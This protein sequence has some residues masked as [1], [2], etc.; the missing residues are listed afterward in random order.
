MHFD[1]AKIDEKFALKSPEGRI[2][3]IT[4]ARVA[5]NV[6]ATI[7]VDGAWVEEVFVQVIN[8]LENVA[9]H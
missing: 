9:L 1:A 5:G 2:A 4:L 3:P 8:E 6:V 7:F